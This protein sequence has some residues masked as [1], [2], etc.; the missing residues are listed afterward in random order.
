MRLAT[1]EVPW[2][3]S[4]ALDVPDPVGYLELLSL[5]E[6][7]YSQQGTAAIA[8]ASPNRKMWTTSHEK[9]GA[10]SLFSIV[11]VTHHLQAGFATP[12]QRTPNLCLLDA[13]EAFCFLPT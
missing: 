11:M 7:S 13:K 10:A 5:L 12:L 8:T 2:V 3:V 6:P 1:V 4:A 9:H